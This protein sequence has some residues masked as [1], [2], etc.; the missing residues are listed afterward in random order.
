M[1]FN[2]RLNTILKILDKKKHISIKELQ[3]LTYESESTL[4]RDLIKLE[5]DNKVVRSSGYVDLIKKNVTEFGYDIRKG[6]QCSQKKYISE[7]AADFI[8][9]SQAL[10]VDSST[11]TSY[12]DTYIKKKKRM[13]V[14]TNGINIAASLNKS[15]NVRTFISGGF[16]KHSSGSIVGTTSEAFFKEFKADVAFISCEAIDGNG[17]YMASD[18]QSSVKKQMLKNAELN[19]L[20]AD[21]SKFMTKNFYVLSDFSSI[22]VIITDKRPPQEM[23]DILDNLRIELV[24]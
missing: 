21:S 7:L 2:D 22:D 14:V 24:Y 1:E 23:I 19:I 17:V 20:M 9:D 6:K 10:F 4:R 3:K 8:G 13:V 12:L 15:S 5:E 16:L 11:T 18:N